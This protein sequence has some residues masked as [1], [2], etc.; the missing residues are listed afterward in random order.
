MATNTPNYN[1]VKPSGNPPETG[2]DLV[3]VAVINSNMDTIDATMHDFETRI[4]DLEVPVPLWTS[5]VFQNGWSNQ[6]GAY[7][8]GAY[9]KVNGLVRFRGFIK[10]GTL[11]SGTILFNVPAGYRSNGNMIF[12][13]ASSAGGSPANMVTVLPNG[14]VTLA[15][16]I[17]T[18]F[19]DI[20][21]ISYY[22][23]K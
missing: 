15:S 6:G 13:C 14:D 1:L 4:T 9:T 3:D 5:V 12:L 2:G 23:E 7:Y 20:C 18:G 22:A 21:S 8:A 17:T 11:A 10:G 16:T 19:L